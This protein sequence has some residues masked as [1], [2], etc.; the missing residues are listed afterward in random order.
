MNFLQ[1]DAWEQFQKSLGRQV[2]RD[3]GDDWSYLAI[4]E[5]GRGNSRLYCPYGPTATTEKGLK[6]AI[7]SLKQ[8]ANRLNATFIRIEPTDPSLLPYLSTN[9]FQ[10]VTYQSLNPE[11]TSL[12]DLSQDKQDMLQAMSQPVRNIYRNYHKKNFHVEKSQNPSDIGH[13]LKLIHQVSDRTGMQPHSDKYF[14]AQADAL[15]PSSDASLWLAK[16]E[17]VTI[18]AAITYDSDD[19]RYYAHAAADLSPDLRKL[20]AATAIVA[21]SI[22]DAKEQGLKTYD[23]YGIAPDDAPDN[24]P[25]KGFTKFKRSFGGTDYHHCGSWDLPIKPLAYRLYRWY[26]KLFS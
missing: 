9:K 7:D 5:K 11:H 3:S 22:F 24:H 25:W 2:F 18:A 26:Q 19:T 20:N 1:S 10:K 15:L 6:L 21:E 16:F 12:I 8:L 14:T 23:L 13:F 17:D 4:L